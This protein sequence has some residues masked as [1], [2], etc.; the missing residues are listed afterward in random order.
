MN[1]KALEIRIGQRPVGILF[2][3]PLAPD[4]IIN[5]FVADDAFAR[6]PGQELLSLSFKAGE[7]EAQAAFWAAVTGRQLN[8]ALSSDPKRGWLLP[9]FF[10]NLLPEGPL[11][12]RI[13]E[14]RGC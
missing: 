14:M 7:P 12:N 4:Q 5:R 2:Q 1:L 9:A 11:R 3:Y 6:D 10:Q 8:G 13:A